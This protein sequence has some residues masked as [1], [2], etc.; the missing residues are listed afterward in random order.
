M[1]P[2]YSNKLNNIIIQINEASC[3]E[4]QMPSLVDDL[5]G[6]H[7]FLVYKSQCGALHKLLIC[8]LNTAALL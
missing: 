5:V 7:R 8:G 6:C 2:N 1:L 3:Q 4:N